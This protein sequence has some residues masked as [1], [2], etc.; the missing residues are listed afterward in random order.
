MELRTGEEHDS[1]E[2]VLSE[3]T[4]DTKTAVDACDEAGDPDILEQIHQL[5]V[6]K[7]ESL[8]SG[9][10][11][12]ADLLDN[13]AGRQFVQRVASP[14]QVKL[15]AALAAA[16]PD[17]ASGAS[18]G[19]ASG[20][21]G[22]EDV[23]PLSEEGCLRAQRVGEPILDYRFSVLN[24][25]VFDTDH[26]FWVDAAVDSEELFDTLDDY[27]WL[28]YGDEECSW[29]FDDPPGDFWPLPGCLKHDVGLSSLQ[30]FIG[31]TVDENAPDAAFNPR[32]KQLTDHQ[33]AVDLECTP[34][35]G[36]WDSDEYHSCAASFDWTK[37][38]LSQIHWGCYGYRLVLPGHDQK[39]LGDSF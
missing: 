35:R 1:L 33:F 36:E 10:T 15:S 18:E 4:G 19:G 2:D 6:T 28:N 26:S 39:R 30:R 8:K 25:L 3:Y 27:A 37:P 12:Y 29:V 34:P 21:S 5:F 11:R 7:L 22:G 24:C 31:G 20:Q 9:N 38:I 13:D 17:A 32:N 16:Q 14:T 23:D